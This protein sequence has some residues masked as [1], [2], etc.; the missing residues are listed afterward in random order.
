MFNALTVLCTIA[1]HI[2]LVYKKIPLL[3]KSFLVNIN[4]VKSTDFYKRPISN[5][6]NL[7]LYIIVK[8]CF[9]NVSKQGINLKINFFLLD[10][11]KLNLFDPGQ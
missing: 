2:F 6:C 4:T 9:L 11:G 7:T 8:G 3:G 1:F 5:K 10:R